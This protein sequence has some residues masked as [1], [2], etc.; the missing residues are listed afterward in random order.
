M[1]IETAPDLEAR[2]RAAGERA[3]V[4]VDELADRILRAYLDQPRNADIE[5]AWIT[6]TQAGLSRVWPIEDFS[7]WSLVDHRTQLDLPQSRRG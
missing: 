7:D 4:S 5:R 2:L 1:T 6:A 3:S